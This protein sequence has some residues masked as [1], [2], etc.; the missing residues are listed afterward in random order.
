[1]SF[2]ITTP[3]Q[4]HTVHYVLEWAALA[5]GAWVYRQRKTRQGTASVLQGA[6]FPIVMG[7]LLGAAI[8]NKS[9]FWLENPQ[10]WP[11]YLHF[12]TLWLQG[13]SIVGGLLGGWIGVEL[14]KWLSGWTGPRTGDDFVP[15]ILGGILVGRVGCFLAGLN[16]GTYGVPTTLPWGMDMGDGVQRHPTALYEW[17]VALLALISWPRWGQALAHTPG[18][19]FR[20]F[21]LGY[22]LWRLVVDGIKPVPY[23]YWGGLSGIQWVCLLAASIVAASLVIERKAP[24][25]ST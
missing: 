5:T 23:A 16:D 12:P 6:T 19:A 3:S 17:L 25:T 14:A 24:R 18:L 11:L 1:M 4:A 13:Q 8:G 21:M 9:M 7:C 22:L 20:C 10:L 15:A 2:F